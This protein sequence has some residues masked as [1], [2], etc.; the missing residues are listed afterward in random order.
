[1]IPD[2]LKMTAALRLSPADSIGVPIFEA[3]NAMYVP[4]MDADYNISAFL[5]YENVDHYDVVRYLPDSYRDR[6]FRV[7]D[8][9][10]IIF[11]HKQAPYIIEGDAERARL[12]AMFGVDALT[13]PL[14]RDLGEM[15]DDARSG[16]VKAQQE[17]WFAQEIEA[18]YNDVFLEEPS[19]TRYWV[20]RY[21]VA[22]E[23]ARKLTQPPHPIDVRLRRASS[24]WLELYAT[25]AEFPMLTSILGEASQG[26]YS[27]KQITDIMF[28]YMAHRVGAVSSVEIT[29]WLEDD[30][31][32]SLFGRGL[33]DMYLL[34]GWPHVPFEYIKPDFLG[35]LKERLT[36]GWERETWKV[37]RLVSVLILG[38]KEAPREID[39][40]AMVYMR[41]V[42]RDYERALYHAQNNFGR[43]PTYNDELPVEVAKTIVER[44]EQAT[45]LSCIMHGDDRMR[46]R[47]QLNRFGLDEEQ[48]QMYR[49]Y[50]ANFRT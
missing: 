11:W 42:L 50:I 29:R 23:N 15:L 6:L 27:L 39:D 40:L 34:D 9:A 1:M 46:G 37:A 28:A 44:H 48:A 16:K 22:L 13:H 12:K 18:S 43:N 19:R 17:E 10:P 20:S 41:D 25:K 31:V 36:Q 14:L 35:L 38:S 47:V 3:G 8:P 45:D 5:L 21:R 24:R 4:E 2:G 32:R 30:T 7:G 49:D 26:I 33:Y